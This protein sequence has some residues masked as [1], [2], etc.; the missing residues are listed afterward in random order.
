[1]N[2]NKKPTTHNHQLTVIR[3]FCVL[4]V[5]IFHISQ[6]TK[7][8]D[9]FQFG[10]LGVIGFFT[11]SS[12]LICSKL[13]F[14]NFNYKMFLKRRFIRIYPLFIINFFLFA[15]I[16]NL[17]TNSRGN[18]VTKWEFYNMLDWYTLIANYSLKGEQW[19]TPFSHLWSICVEMHFYLIL[20][21]LAKFSRANRNIILFICVFASIILNYYVSQNFVYPSVWVQSSSHLGSFA[22]GALIANNEKFLLSKN[23]FSNFLILTMAIA[24]YYLS[25]FREFFSGKYTG[26][27]YLASSI[28]FGLIILK[29]MVS[30]KKN[31][32]MI[33]R[34]GL[35]SYSIYLV[36]FPFIYV[37]VIYFNYASGLNFYNS[38]I[39]LFAILAVSMIIYQIFEKPILKLKSKVDIT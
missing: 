18:G 16:F 33:H 36:H 5:V 3:G 10:N 13:F 20:P 15:I 7:A 2:V 28:F 14:Q 38:V 21:L 39:C 23:K 8:S 6:F 25:G 17:L 34:I 22:L 26:I 24:L 19:V 1:M 12:Y 29:C 35:M 31:F 4:I 32:S 30:L 11:L 27:S 9:N 37:Y